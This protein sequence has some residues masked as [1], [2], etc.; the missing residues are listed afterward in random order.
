VRVPG[1]KVQVPLS[2]PM[3]PIP[4]GLNHSAR[5]CA[6]SAT[7][8]LPTRDALNPERGMALTQGVNRTWIPPVRS[9]FGMRGG[10][11]RWK[12]KSHLSTSKSGSD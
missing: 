2:A 7:L 5:G 8:G 6:S 10:H 3:V 9:K 4:T 12:S 11:F 1:S